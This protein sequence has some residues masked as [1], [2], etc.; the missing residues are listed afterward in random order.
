VAH[1]IYWEPW[2]R[3]AEYL[4]EIVRKY[5]QYRGRLLRAPRHSAAA[6]AEAFGYPL[7]T[8]LTGYARSF[9]AESLLAQTGSRLTFVQHQTPAEL[10]AELGISIPQHTEWLH[11]PHWVTS[12]GNEIDASAIIPRRPI[13]LIAKAVESWP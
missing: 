7:T 5:R 2:W 13:D 1:R 3:P 9:R 10:S 4:D 12:A 8:A 11:C 6:Q